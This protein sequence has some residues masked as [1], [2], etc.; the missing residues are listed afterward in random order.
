VKQTII[1]RK[2]RLC[3]KDLSRKVLFL[4]HILFLVRIR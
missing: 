4:F 3:K 2:Y 1:V